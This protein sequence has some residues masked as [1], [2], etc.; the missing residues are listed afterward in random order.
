VPLFEFAL[1]TTIGRFDLDTPEGRTSALRAAAPVVAQ[2]RDQ[3]LRPEYA[4]TLA[5]WLGMEVEPVVRAVAQ[6]GRKSA[7]H[8][9]PTSRYALP[10]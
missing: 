2:I 5:G 4:R 3:S 1:R 6:A 7:S 9:V 10:K 8:Q